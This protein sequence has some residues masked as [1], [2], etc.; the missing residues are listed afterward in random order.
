MMMMMVVI[1]IIII[2][3]NNK[4]GACML[5]YVAISRDR[6]VIIDETKKILTL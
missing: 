2:I 5:I 6:N 1:I 4:R 3:R